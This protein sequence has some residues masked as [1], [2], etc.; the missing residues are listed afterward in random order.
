MKSLLISCLA[1]ASLTPA[2]AANL[3]LGGTYSYTTSP[4]PVFSGGTHY[5]DDDA[6]AGEHDGYTTPGAYDNGD[7]NDGEIFTT[8]NPVFVGSPIVA[9]DPVNVTPIPVTI[10]FDLG[11]LADISSVKINSYVR[12]DFALG[13][14]DDYDLSFSTDNIT[15]TTPTPVITGFAFTTGD[16]NH[17]EV[18]NQQARYVK[19]D[20]DGDSNGGDKFGLTEISIEG[21][22]VPEPSS[23][24]LLGLTS[25]IL[26]KRRR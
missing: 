4:M 24:S 13:A 6:T 14:P 2:Y 17:T 20:F 19:F 25:L 11:S 21:T 26:L 3:A 18:V 10:I 23:L 15:F 5:R 12:T 16:V 9:W 7:L 1:V 22:A 8:G